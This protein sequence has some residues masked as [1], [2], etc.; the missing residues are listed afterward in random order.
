MSTVADQWAFERRWR[1]G[2]NSEPEA[3]SS[4]LGVA[5]RLAA[6]IMPARRLRK[7][8]FA[9]TGPAAANHCHGWQS[10]E[11]DRA[12]G[13]GREHVGKQAGDHHS[14]NCRVDEKYTHWTLP[15]ASRAG[16]LTCC[17]KLNNLWET[18]Q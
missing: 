6:L 18:K 7:K 1:S 10:A 9:K 11:M 16:R 12:D 15:R 2:V 14:C 4:L 13:L 17:G 8:Q 3:F 5:V